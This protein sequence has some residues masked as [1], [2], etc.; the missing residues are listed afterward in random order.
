MV[1]CLMGSL[2]SGSMW[3]MEVYHWMQVF[4]SPVIALGA[5]ALEVDMSGLAEE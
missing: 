4:S 2:A 5:D 1:H 3:K